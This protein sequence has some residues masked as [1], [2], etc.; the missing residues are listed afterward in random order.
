MAH[1]KGDIEVS[2]GEVRYRLRRLIVERLIKRGNGGASYQEE[3]EP[4]SERNPQTMSEP[5]W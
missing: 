4:G 2:E 3:S 5:R 1:F